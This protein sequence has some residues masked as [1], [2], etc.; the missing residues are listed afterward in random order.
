[1]TEEKFKRVVISSTVGAV[2]LLFI[3]LAIMVY[4]LIAINVEQKN[5]AKLESEIVRLTELKKNG[6]DIYEIRQLEEWI[7]RRA[8][9]LG[10]NFPSDKPL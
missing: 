10:Y 5:I 4:Q 6:E 8:Y 2:L 3:L 9:E 7:V 1:M